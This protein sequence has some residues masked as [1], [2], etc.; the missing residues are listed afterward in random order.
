MTFDVWLAF[1]ASC[2]I[3]SLS[4]GAGAIS[5]MSSGLRF[6]FLNGY[7]NVIGLQLALAVQIA[8]VAAGIGALLVASAVAFNIVKWFG[9]GY[10]FYL[11]YKQWRLVPAECVANFSASQS[12]SR[13]ALITK[14]FLVNISN[15]KAIVFILAVLPQFLNPEK[16]LLPQ[17]SL[18]TVTMISVDMIVMAGYTG[19][20]ARAFWLLNSPGHLHLLNRSFACMFAGAASMLA[21]VHRVR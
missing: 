5:S 17:Y 3:I 16:A 12:V 15:P 4:P 14:G 13:T 6:G 18:M 8:I 2:W 10:L 21:W 19:L 11:A 7:W 20:A 1:F 9:V